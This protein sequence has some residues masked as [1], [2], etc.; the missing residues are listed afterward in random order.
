VLHSGAML[1]NRLP[2][3]LAFAAG[4]LG[5]ALVGFSR[6]EPETAMPPQTRHVVEQAV[7]PSDATIA[8]TNDARADALPKD[9][10]SAEPADA[11]AHGETAPE[12]GNSIAEVLMRLEASYRQARAE[13]EEEPVAAAGETPPA[14]AEA[15][16][17]SAPAP[18][19]SAA[20]PPAAIA[21]ASAP[22]AAV[23]ALPART[24]APASATSTVAAETVPVAR[25]RSDARAS[26]I[27]VGEVHQNIYLGNV[28]RGD[29]LQ[30]QQLQLQQLAILEYLQLLALS[31]QGSP[32]SP[33]RA[34]APGRAPAR[35]PRPFSMALTN[36]DNPW[37][38]DFPPTVLV[39]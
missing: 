3:L 9:A 21:A 11:T 22:A 33:G 13:L 12:A 29:V 10:Q 35:R 31:S 32:A 26:D 14:A 1:A 28:H 15:V 18:A 7:V 19:A 30:V 6:G 38:F 23:A 16:P 5:T 34:Q 20:V 36:P 2:L 25:A 39:K 27:H 4:S 17:A 24:D 8:V 37:G